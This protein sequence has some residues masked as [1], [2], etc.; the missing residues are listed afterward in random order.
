MRLAPGV[1]PTQFTLPKISEAGCIIARVEAWTGKTSLT[2]T[3]RGG[4]QSSQPATANQGPLWVSYPV[5]A[6]QT[7]QSWVVE[8]LRGS[9]GDT[10][11]GTLFVEYP[12]TQVPCQLAAKVNGRNVTMT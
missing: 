5:S 7:S 12:P 3:I 9:G 4:R 10:L 11:S 2:L 8:A 1:K 6:N